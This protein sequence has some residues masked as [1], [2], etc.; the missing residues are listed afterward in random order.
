LKSFT[1]RPGPSLAIGDGRH[2]STCAF[3][4]DGQT[5]AIASG[6]NI[7]LWELATGRKLHTLT[8]H[9][10][11]VA[12]LAFSGDGKSLAS[13][14]WGNTVKL[15]EVATGR[16]GQTIT[17][18]ANNFISSV[19]LSHDGR[20]LASVSNYET[21]KLW[22]AATGREVWT[23]KT[24]AILNDIAFSPDDQSLAGGD[25]S[26]A[27]KV[28]EAT[29]GRELQTLAGHSKGVNSIALSNDGKTLAT[30]DDVAIT[31]WDVATGQGIRTLST[32]KYAILSLAFSPNNRILVSGS[33]DGVIRV[34]DITTGQELRR[35]TEHV[36]S[37]SRSPILFAFAD[38][39]TLASLSLGTSNTIKLWDLTTG[40]ERRAFHLKRFAIARSMALSGDGRMLAVSY[41]NT[42]AEVGIKVW[43]VATGEEIRTLRS[44]ARAVYSVA[45]SSDGQILASGNDDNTIKLWEV[46]TG[47]EILTLKGHTGAVTA[48]I[49]SNDRRTLASASLDNTI[50]LWDVTMGRELHNLTG[51]LELLTSIAFSY[52]GRTLVSGSADAT[53][54]LWDVPTG[55][56]LATLLAI[57]QQDWLVVN[58]G[59]LFDG[60]PAAWSKMIWRAPENT[61]DFVP[62]EAYF[63]DYY[64]PGLL[65]EIFAGK[66]P[67][68]PSDI[69][70]K[71]RRQP[72]LKLT[73][74]D[75]RPEIALATRKVTVKIEVS[76]ALAGAQDV[77]LF[78][79]GLLVK[80]WEGDVLKRQSS[81]TLTAT[82]PIVA[83]ENRLTAYAFNHD[84]IKSNDATLTVTGADSLKRLGTSYIL[85]VGVNA[86]SNPGYNLKYAVPDAA[87]FA[88]EV[89]RQQGRLKNSSQ[90]EIISLADSEAT[91]ANIMQQLAQLVERVQ[92]EDKV[93]VYFAGHGTA[94]QNRFY[95]IPHD[96]GYAGPRARL[97]EAG[98]QSMLAHSISDIELDQAFEKMDAG[99]ILLVIDAC[100]SGQALEAE[101]KRRGPMNSKG[102]AQL[103][104][105]KGMYILTA[106]QSYQAAQEA[107][108]LG[109]GFLTYALVEDGLK[110]GA[111]DGEPKDGR[112]ELREWLNYAT[113]Q[114]P[115]M[116]EENQLEARRGRGRFINFAGDGTRG[117]QD[118][119][120]VQRPRIFYRRELETNPLVIAVLGATRP[121]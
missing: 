69:S 114:V 15:W 70:Q 54:K 110:R 65:A 88:A 112:I 42:S 46:A 52:D 68:A 24:Q 96:L 74:A 94:Q 3:S 107:A 1:R 58:P 56:E 67:K 37:I 21:V 95:L 87:E 26:N 22:D 39:K 57:D 99:Q 119:G 76:P 84:N 28:W 86:Y 27:I 2:L 62:V 120:G 59:G 10:L 79:N 38:G 19:A 71:D 103:A 7:E 61:Y 105:E 14:D 20:T 16:E 72:Q 49:F 17:V 92:P 31:L 80:L 50:R 35:L 9:V 90:I 108:K 36:Y 78:R 13:G 41:D 83:G 97:N 93:I 66:R 106:A 8:G 47:Q 34:W 53:V 64:Y 40:R 101:E 117:E 29:G 4:R 102:L 113:E 45:F 100:N 5:L 23:S 82:I 43:A 111:A 55:K 81:V 73:L 51:H 60:S 104:Y 30:C 18:T 11:A 121:Q 118:K 75:A 115:R 44:R 116:Q 98:L 48:V 25:E 12:A 77:R 91:K 33:E 63:S 85:A 89:K 109:H 6:F 32:D